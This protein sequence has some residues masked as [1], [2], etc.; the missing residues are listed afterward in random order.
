MSDKKE[1]DIMEV[2]TQAE[3]VVRSFSK[4]K[5]F[6]EDLL[7]ENERLRYKILDLQQQAAGKEEPRGGDALDT[8]QENRRL[9]DELEKIKAHFDNL[10]RENKDFQARYEEVEQQNEN[11]LNLYVSGYQLHSTLQEDTVLAVIQEILL[12]LLGAEV[13][14]LWIVDQKSGELEPLIVIDENGFLGGPPPRLTAARQEE[15]VAG[16][17]VFSSG[18]EGKEGEALACIPLQLEEKTQGVLVIYKLLEQKKS[19]TSLDQELLNLLTT[20][21]ATAILGS[22]A[23]SR[24][25]MKLRSLGEA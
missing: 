9:K 8:E 4:G 1:R 5:R 10:N 18:S 6:A 25:G 3:E 22:M 2:F 14:A 15:M 19:L 11:L 12:N 17:S 23:L 20:Q 7:R 16:K 24:T 21:A 13:F